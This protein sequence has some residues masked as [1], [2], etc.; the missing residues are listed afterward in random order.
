MASE[1]ENYDQLDNDNLPV[2]ML[3]DETQ[4]QHESVLAGEDAFF[5]NN[6]MQQHIGQHAHQSDAEDKKQRDRRDFA[7]VL[8][9]RIDKIDAQIEGIDK[10]IAEMNK[11]L[12][13]LEQ[14][15]TELE[16]HRYQL[17]RHFNQIK[18][19]IE[20]SQLERDAL[21]EKREICTQCL[22]D[23][24]HEAH[25]I[26][27]QQS[28][29]LSQDEKDDL[30]RQLEEQKE[31]IVQYQEELEELEDSISDCDAR[32]EEL[33]AEGQVCRIEIDKATSKIAHNCE[34]MDSHKAEIIELERKKSELLQERKQIEN[35]LDSYIKSAKGF[36]TNLFCS[37][38]SEAPPELD[39]VGTEYYEKAR[40]L[41]ENGQLSD[42]NVDMVLED[43]SEAT[44][45]GVLA[46]LKHD[47]IKII[48]SAGEATSL[49][50]NSFKMAVDFATAEPENGPSLEHT[51]PE[52]VP[53]D[54]LAFKA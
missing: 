11:M 49:L 30:N 2:A 37:N 18:T 26:E 20:N 32:I 46:H 21:L 52:N 28:D 33:R 36:L 1:P 25:S 42:K 45:D 31:Q 40:G 29:A 4:K 24:H 7:L 5:A 51:P 6:S 53:D 9:K 12:V 3:D 10:R 54:S 44:R 17:E 38:S 39:D 35:K 22:K 15:N 47:G 48:N 43:A 14:H 19:D 23:A 16:G 41:I 50:K 27:D 13:D 34:I 8:Q